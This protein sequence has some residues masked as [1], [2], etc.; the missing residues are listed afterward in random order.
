VSPKGKAVTLTVDELKQQLKERSE[1]FQS[2][3]VE[4]DVV[5]EAHVDPRLLMNW[6]LHMIRDYQEHHRIA[7]KGDK[8][9]TQE[10][11]PE[12]LLKYIPED[13]MR[14]DP[15]APT[16][17]VRAVEQQQ[18][19]AAT[20]KAQGSLSYLVARQHAEEIRYIYDGTNCY[21]WSE[22]ARRMGRAQPSNFYAPVM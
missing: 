8:R 17:V 6:N 7:F 9:Y 10:L 19:T 2:L 21:Q 16:E 14:P 11:H 20:R 13:Q 3:L 1:R 12:A 5:T 22:H 18:Q 4:Y 15:K